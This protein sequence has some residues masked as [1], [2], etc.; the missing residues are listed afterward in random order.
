ML[1]RAAGGEEVAVAGVVLVLA[2]YRVCAESERHLPV[3]LRVEDL[4]CVLCFFY[5]P[6][7]MAGRLQGN[8]LARVTTLWWPREQQC[9]ALRRVRIHLGQGGRLCRA[10]SWD[11][12]NRAKYPVRW[13]FCV[14]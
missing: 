6:S 5:G 10:Q 8:C 4:W 1:K 13:C 7:T 14:Q 2:V 11:S 12:S 3:S 9:L